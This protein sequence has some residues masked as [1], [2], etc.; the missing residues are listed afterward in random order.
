MLVSD[1]GTV[2]NVPGENKTEWEKLRNLS[3][4]KGDILTSVEISFKIKSLQESFRL[5]DAAIGYVSLFIRKIFFD[6]LSLSECEAKLGSMLA[7]TGGDPSQSHAIVEFV[8]REILTI[9]PQAK[10][11]A[12]EEKK[13]AVTIVNLPLLQAL[14]KYEQL[15]N[16]LITGERIKIKKQTE[17]VR[18]SLIYWLKYYRDELGV[19]Y[20]DSVKRGNFLF[21]SENCKG[22]S[23]EERERINLILRSVEEDYPL[24]IDTEKNEIIFPD[25]A[26]FSRSATGES[27]HALS[28]RPQAVFAEKPVWQNPAALVKPAPQSFPSEPRTMKQSTGEVSR[29]ASGFL[30]KNEEIQGKP[31]A[32]TPPRIPELK[33]KRVSVETTKPRRPNFGPAPAYERNEDKV[34]M[35]VRPETPKQFSS[36][37]NVSVGGPA[38]SVPTSSGHKAGMEESDSYAGGGLAISWKANQR[39]SNEVPLMKEDDGLSFSSKHIFPAE[40][41]RMQGA[42]PSVEDTPLAAKQPLPI[43]KPAAP[44]VSQSDRNPFHIRP[45]SA[46]KEE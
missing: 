24:S 14:S 42:L 35:S 25:F 34:E 11:E 8:Q 39:D 29:D 37:G 40:K 23:A 46:R 7:T 43:T 22:L 20:H 4:E 21:R 18:P 13:L 15:G 27:V 31:A 45:V 3:S 33:P 38:E 9:K 2:C 5:N 1:Q 44:S 6:E 36:P 12:A 26:A 19:G 10:Q 32:W 28:D 30:A 17:P 41:E 16:Q